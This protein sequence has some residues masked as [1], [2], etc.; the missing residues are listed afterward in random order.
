MAER[1]NH[2]IQRNGTY[3]LKRRVPIRYSHVEEREIIWISL[4]TDSLGEAE[5]KAT[6]IWKEQIAGWK[7]KLAGKHA[8][9]NEHFAAVKDLAELKGYRY[10]PAQNVSRLP[11]EDILRRVEAIATRN[12]EPDI[13]QANALLGGIQVP[14]MTVSQVL[15]AY[16][17]LARDKVL[18][19]SPDQKRRWCNPRI[20]AVNNFIKLIGDKEFAKITRDDALKF[21]SWWL[22]RVECDGLT[23]NSANKDLVHLR[24]VLE[25]VN[26]LLG[27]GLKLPFDKL[28][29]KDD[30]RPNRPSFSKNW[31]Q[32]KLLAKGA[33]DGM[34][35]QARVVFLTMINTGARPSE[36]ANLRPE[37]IHLESE[38]PHI[39]INEINRELKS[40]NAIRIIPLAGCSLKAM[41]QCPDGFPKYRDNPSLSGTMNKYLKENGL[42]QTPKHVAYSVRHSFEDRLRQAKIDE[43][44][45]SELFGHAYYRE[46]YGDPTLQELTEAIQLI[47]I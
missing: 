40:K 10:L 16:W 39:N 38:Y 22:D 42:R 15:E 21:R 13:E 29:L 14:E 11:I 3:S 24:S 27:M 12:G 47:A 44:L 18:N 19:K 37:H 17:E 32:E 46:K 25:T 45:R 26:E 2:L 6:D 41:H 35:L 34:N 28:S 5:S 9:A 1:A 23:P 20:K 43:R 7:A 31:I 4:S 33:L 30:E 8:A 36:I